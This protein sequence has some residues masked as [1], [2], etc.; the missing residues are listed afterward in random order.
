MKQENETSEELIQ[1]LQLEITR[2]KMR[3]RAIHNASQN[4]ISDLSL[5]RSLNQIV[6]QITHT[7]NASGSTLSLWHKEENQVE[8]M[9]DYSRQ[10]FSSVD[11]PGSV[12]DLNSFPKTLSIS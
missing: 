10:D 5:E 1:R 2:Y 8:T 9:V 11:K 6:Q 4:M 12:Y 3:E 7:L